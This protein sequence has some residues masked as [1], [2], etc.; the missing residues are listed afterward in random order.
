[1]KYVYKNNIKRFAQFAQRVFDVDT[2]FDEE[3]KMAI[4]GIKRLENFY[5]DIGLPTRLNEVNITSS[6]FEEM[7][8]KCVDRGPIGNFVKLNKQDIVNIYKIA[9]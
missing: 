4:E 9:E 8:D 3:E 2:Y 6:R 5:K 1:M 7:A